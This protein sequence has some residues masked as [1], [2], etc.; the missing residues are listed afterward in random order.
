MRGDG[1]EDGGCGHH[2]HLTRAVLLEVIGF[3]ELLVVSNMGVPHV[4]MGLSP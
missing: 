3:L 4:R 1:D 2:L